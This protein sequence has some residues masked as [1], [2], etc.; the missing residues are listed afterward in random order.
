MKIALEIENIQI[1][2][3]EKVKAKYLFLATESELR[4][5]RNKIGSSGGLNPNERIVGT[6]KDEMGKERSIEIEKISVVGDTTYIYL[7][8]KLIYSK[9]G[10]LNNVLLGCFGILFILCIIGMVI[11]SI[12]IMI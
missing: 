1:E 9:T 5:N 12:L 6:F 7:D 4:V 3:I 11:F 10:A 8:N 2:L